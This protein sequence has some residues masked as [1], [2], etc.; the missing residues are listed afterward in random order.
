MEGYLTQERSMLHIVS[1]VAAYL[2]AAYLRFYKLPFSLYFDKIMKRMRRRYEFW[3]NF[4]RYG[5]SIQ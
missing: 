1:I 3:T 4:N 2:Y 5:N